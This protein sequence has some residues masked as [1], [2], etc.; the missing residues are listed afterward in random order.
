M[1]IKR[2]IKE[3]IPLFIFSLIMAWPHTAWAI[4]IGGGS[5]FRFDPVSEKAVIGLDPKI[6][7]VFGLSVQFS[8]AADHSAEDNPGLEE[9]AGDSMEIDTDAARENGRTE[10]TAGENVSEQI[11]E[12]SGEQIGEQISEQ[13]GE[14]A[15]NTDE[16][17]D[18]GMIEE[19]AGTEREETAA[20]EGWGIA[21]EGAEELSEEADEEADETVGRE[22]VTVNLFRYSSDDG[23]AVNIREEPTTQGRI[24]DSVRPGMTCIVYETDESG[25]WLHIIYESQDQIRADW[26]KREF[27]ELMEEQTLDIPSSEDEQQRIQYIW[28]EMKQSS[29]E[30]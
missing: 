30:Q 1:R 19:T 21:E 6:G 12:R 16:I 27:F 15:G 10:E 29:D 2:I 14:Q 24:I 5:I 8:A 11:S 23:K 25:E 7:P 13:T 22:T 26:V 9:T 20:E 17:T 28:D 4:G 3:V 18:E